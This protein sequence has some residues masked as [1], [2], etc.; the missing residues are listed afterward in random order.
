M[1]NNN[2]SFGKRGE[3]TFHNF[4]VIRFSQEVPNLFK[5][6]LV[7]SWKLEIL[8]VKLKDCSC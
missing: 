7:E 1:D 4:F 5:V 3:G 2:I 8:A 6:R